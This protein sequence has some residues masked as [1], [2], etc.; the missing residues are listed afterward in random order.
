MKEQIITI[1]HSPDPDDAFM[2]YALVAGKIDTTPFVFKH[3]M[4]DIETLNQE[5]RRGTY[6]LTAISYHAY[7]F[8]ADKYYLLRCGSSIGDNYG[9]II[10][11]KEKLSKDDLK[12]KKVAVPGHYTTATLVLKLYEPD[13]EL[14]I[15]MFDK[16]GELVKTGKV[17]AGVII[18]EG[19]LTYKQEG[20]KLIVDLGKWWKDLTGLP[21]PLGGN[22]VR[23]DLGIENAKRLSSLLK[24]SIE[25]GLGNRGE[26]LSYSKKYG[27]DLTQDQLDK[28]IGMYVNDYTLECGKDVEKALSLLYEKAHAVGLIP[29][30]KQI[31]W[32]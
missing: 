27:R 29:K 5:A 9:P 21:L 28:F 20:L 10:V 4:L 32:V 1:A 17:D 13:L 11:S 3:L 19:Q 2:F 7:P 12:G 8:V 16:I 23:K 14:E 25:Y 26:A 18:H 15:A 24:K 22:A 31:E 6:P 30:I